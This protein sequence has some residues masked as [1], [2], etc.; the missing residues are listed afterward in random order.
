MGIFERK[1]CPS[2]GERVSKSWR[3][4]PYCGEE[5]I[6][7]K[8]RP[9]GIFEDIEKEFE[10][11]DKT[12]GS[13]FFR[14]PKIGFKPITRGGGISI[15]ISSATGREPEVEVK[16]SG[17]YKKLEPEI[18]RKL[19]VKPTIEEIQD[20]RKP[21]RIPKVTEEP[22]TK[23]E[24]LPTKDIIRIKLPDVKEGD[25]EIKRLEQSIEI[26]A[27]AD[28]K[29]Y[30][31]LIPIPSNAYISKEFKDGILKIEVER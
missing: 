6:E 18:K 17:E 19:G 2:C 22:E 5:L 12:F 7:R 23:V 21:T 10:R 31:K 16:T 4:C 11:I 29:A 1:R 20:G 8:I 25:I 13:E 26:K 15:T 3:F 30:F 14:F 27:F 28:D 24:H 9:R